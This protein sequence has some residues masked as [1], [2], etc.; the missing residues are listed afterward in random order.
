[1]ICTSSEV[2][3]TSKAIINPFG[4]LVYLTTGN[5]SI[6]NLKIKF[7]KFLQCPFAKYDDPEIWNRTQYFDVPWGEIICENVIFTLPTDKM[8]KIQNFD[9]IFQRFK[10]IIHGIIDFS[11]QGLSVLFGLSSMLIFL[12][13]IHWFS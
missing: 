9:L 12:E 6:T 7:S 4:G 2:R 13:I 5:S 1:L 8:R 10:F 11:I 3:S